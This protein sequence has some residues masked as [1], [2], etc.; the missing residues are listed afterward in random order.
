[1]IDAEA[2]KDAKKDSS[3]AAV[4]QSDTLLAS[5]AVF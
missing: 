4:S 2:A 1:M 5:A 3:R